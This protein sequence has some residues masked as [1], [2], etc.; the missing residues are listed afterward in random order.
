MI[1]LRVVLAAACVLVIFSYADIVLWGRLIHGRPWLPVF[2]GAYHDGM[3][4]LLAMAMLAG[5]LLVWDRLA[6]AA[7]FA[8]TIW[9]FYR[10]GL[11][12]LLYFW[13]DAKPIPDWLTWGCDDGHWC[14]VPG[15]LHGEQVIAN[16]TALVIIW[17]V[18]W[19]G[20]SRVVR[21]RGV[22]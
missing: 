21:S 16:V 7:F 15:P 10:A 13:L 2:D 3:R 20:I 18:L 22:S 4:V 8:L 17:S 19:L 6:E 5:V 11:C 12:D 1:R 9:V 14:I